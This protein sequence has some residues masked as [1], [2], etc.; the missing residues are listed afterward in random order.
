MKNLSISL[1]QNLNE[2]LTRTN[3]PLEDSHPFVFFFLWKTFSAFS[4]EKK[5]KYK[6]TNLRN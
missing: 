5:S 4:S 6:Q 2:K 3:T 1:N